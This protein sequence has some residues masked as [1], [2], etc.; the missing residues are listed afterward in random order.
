MMLI[1]NIYTLVLD[2]RSKKHG[3]ELD[4]KIMAGII[5]AFFLLAG[6]LI[7]AY[8]KAAIQEYNNRPDYQ[9]NP[10]NYKKT[11]KEGLFWNTTYYHE[12]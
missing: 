7:R 10:Q 1:K 5:T 4:A 12:K 8:Y 2:H 3:K 11:I 9:K 6:I